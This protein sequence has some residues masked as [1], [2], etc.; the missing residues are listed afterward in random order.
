MTF[1]YPD[2]ERPFECAKGYINTLVVENGPFLHRLMEDIG[3]QIAGFDGRALVS[4]DAKLLNFTKSVVLL[5]NFILFDINQKP[6]LNRVV[7]ALEKTAMQA[8]FYERSAEILSLLENYLYELSFGYPCDVVFPKL[9]VPALLKAAG[10]QLETDQSSLCAKVLD[11]MELM[12]EFDGQKLF[13]TLNLRAFVSEEEIERFMETVLDRGYSLLMIENRD[14]RRLSF[15][16][17]LVVDEDLCE[18]D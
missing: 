5:D 14:Y 16:K 15:E 18:I 3:S 9:S 7:S 13:I 12:E 1:T 10:V 4:R 11:Y 17:R 6:L 8:E 2:I